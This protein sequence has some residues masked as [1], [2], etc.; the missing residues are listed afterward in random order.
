M[1]PKRL[2][3]LTFYTILKF[4]DKKERKPPENS[5]DKRWIFASVC[6]GADG[7]SLLLLK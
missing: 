5:K 3:N 7:T 1:I 4:L 2:L 6:E